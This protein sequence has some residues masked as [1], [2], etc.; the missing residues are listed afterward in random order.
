MVRK[1]GRAW[2][3][4]NSSHCLCR[5]PRNNLKR[6]L[7]SLYLT[8][9]IIQGPK[10]QLVRPAIGT[11]TRTTRC[12]VDATYHPEN[13]INER[14][15]SAASQGDEL[16]DSQ[17]PVASVELIHAEGTEKQREN[18]GCALLSVALGG[19]GSL[20]KPAPGPCSQLWR[21]VSTKVL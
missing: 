19:R 6:A 2:P 14:P 4:V 17:R 12:A 11:A 15:E 16:E 18:H 10:V 7:L 21:F 1:G 20:V 13:N 9:A 8:P 3:M 5:R